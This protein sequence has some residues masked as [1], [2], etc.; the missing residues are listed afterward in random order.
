MSTRDEVQAS[1]TL[2]SQS[3]SMGVV[4]IEP[5]LHNFDPSGQALPKD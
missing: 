3:T 1:A 4:T 2:I 5:T